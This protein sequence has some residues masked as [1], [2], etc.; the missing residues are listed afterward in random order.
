VRSRSLVFTGAAV[1]LLAVLTLRCS[2]QP[3]PAA[4]SP[5]AAQTSTDPKDLTEALLLGS[6]PLS[7]PHNRGCAWSDAVAGWPSGSAIK[8]RVSTTVREDVRPGI[9]QVVDRIAEAT[10]GNVT[11]SLEL[12]DETI[13]KGA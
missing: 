6:G 2:K 11:A 1:S 9:Q 13:T 12:T 7:D 10:L 8:V 4:P 5:S 3:S